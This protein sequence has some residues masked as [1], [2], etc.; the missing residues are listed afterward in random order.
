M[1]QAFNLGPT[2]TDQ[3]LATMAGTLHSMYFVPGAVVGTVKLHDGT[4]TA[5][6][7][8]VTVDTPAA[9]GPLGGAGSTLNFG[10]GGV[11]FNTA[12]YAELA[13]SGGLTIVYATG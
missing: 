9:T 7:K 5:G 12:V 10:G 11:R 2:A 13:N 6:T 8:R 4:S 3:A 1:S